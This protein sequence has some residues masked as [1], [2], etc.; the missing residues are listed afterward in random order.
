MTSHTQSCYKC[1]FWSRFV[2]GNNSGVKLFV[3]KGSPLHFCSVYIVQIPAVVKPV[4]GHYNKSILIAEFL[5]VCLCT[6]VVVGT[7]PSVKQEQQ[8]GLFAYMI[9][10]EYQNSVITLQILRFEYY[11]LLGISLFCYCNTKNKKN[12]GQGNL[13]CRQIG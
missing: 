1:P 3:K 4:R 11:S 7:A 12:N 8:R 6:P 13:V 10:S 2:F 9:G 5:D